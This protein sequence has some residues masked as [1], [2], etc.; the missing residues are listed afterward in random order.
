MKIAIGFFGI[1]R[2]LKYTIKS[3]NNNIFNILKSNNIDYDTYIHSYILSSYSNIRS[4]ESIEDGTTVDNEEYKLLNPQYFI[5]DNQDEIKKKLNLLS[6][7]SHKDIWNS[8]YNSVDNY[9]L[10]SYSKYILTG[11]IEKNINEY[12]YVLFIRPD[13]LYLD[14]L[15]INFFNL[16]N[17]KTIVTPNNHCFGKYNINDRFAITNKKTYKIYGEI[18]NHLLNASKKEPLHSETILGEIV[19]KNN[20]IKNLKVRFNFARIRCN[21]RIEDLELTKLYNQYKCC[22]H[23]ELER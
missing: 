5:Q 19:I 21:G 7:R 11:M 13:C 12:D 2:S 15:D 9:I 22:T 16:V 17:D 8:N 23:L 14:K 20:K 10:G 6:Y 18:F 1:T 4:R 3:I